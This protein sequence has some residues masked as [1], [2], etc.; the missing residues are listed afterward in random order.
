MPKKSALPATAARASTN[1]L[2]QNLCQKT[3]F[4]YAIEHLSKSDKVRFYYA[5]KGRDG[6][7]GIVKE[8]AIEQLGRAV[9]LVDKS[10]QKDLSEFLAYWKCAFEQRKVWIE[11][12]A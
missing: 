11:V 7:T 3:I 6:K 4:T 9:L 12:A 2:P 8:W 5:L 10:H 1:S